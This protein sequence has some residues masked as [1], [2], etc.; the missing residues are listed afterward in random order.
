[1]WLQ[2]ANRDVVAT[3]EAGDVGLDVKHRGAVQHVDP[4]EVY[5]VARYPGDPD[6]GEPQ[7]IGP[8]RTADG[9][10]TVFLTLQI[11]SPD[12]LLPAGAV[13]IGD[14]PGVAEPVEVLQPRHVSLFEL[15]VCLRVVPECALDG[16][17]A[18]LPARRMHD[19]DGTHPYLFERCGLCHCSR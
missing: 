10:Y 8:M 16:Q 15:Y 13:E 6:D 19:P 5:P 9:E 4:P 18:G 2:P 14:D 17:V 11:R 7:M 12:E 3:V 1:M